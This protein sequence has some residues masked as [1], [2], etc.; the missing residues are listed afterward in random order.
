MIKVVSI[1]ELKQLE[2]ELRDLEV[3]QVLDIVQRYFGNIREYISANSSNTQDPTKD[4]CLDVSR[5]MNEILKKEGVQALIL[6]G[7]IE[8]GKDSWLEHHI[9]FVMLTNFWMTI[10]LSVGQLEQYNGTPFLI[11]ITEPDRS[12]LQGALKDSYG[13]WTPN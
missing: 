8:I 5:Y 12:L 9:S 4:M 2:V 6:Q 13:W 11:L 7:E 10:D 1:R 3:T